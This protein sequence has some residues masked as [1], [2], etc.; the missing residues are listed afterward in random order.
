M[1]LSDESTIANK[2]CSR[3]WSDDMSGPAIEKRL[4]VVASLYRLW[5]A[6]KKARPRN[7]DASSPQISR[8]GVPS[9]AAKK[10]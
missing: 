9:V 10:Q 6:L 1:K 4:Q 5:M 7:V 8:T 3:G 2:D